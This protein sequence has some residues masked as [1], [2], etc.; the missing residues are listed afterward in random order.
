MKV[1]KFL[2]YMEEIGVKKAVILK[3][4]NINYFLNNYFPFAIALVFEDHPYLY[5][6]KLDKDYASSL[7]IEVREF[8]NWKEIFNNCDAVEEELPIKFLKYLND[9]KIISDKI[10]E[11]RAIKDKDEIKKIEKAVNI[12]D[13]VMDYIY[14]NICYYNN[15]MILCAEIE[16]LM[17]K[18]GS[19]K[20]A[21][22]SIVISGKKT[23]YPHALPEDKKI[24]DILLID[25]GAVYEGYCSD[26][27]RTF[28]LNNN[29]EMKKIYNLVKSAK[30]IVEEH[31]KEG[32][33]TGYL[34][35]LVRKHFGEYN[36]YFIH[37]LGHGVG[38]EVHENPNFRENI[39]LK[40]NMV[41]TIEPGIYI[42]D[43]FGVRLEDMYLIKKNKAKKLSNAK[44]WEDEI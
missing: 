2:N 14:N 16:Y 44:M 1:K 42:K 30:E 43:K 36:N 7:D 24:E 25:I 3:K 33:K 26:I 8:K 12:V 35:E 29:E 40:E 31:L 9:Y 4:E 34:D 6:G 23:S 20:P 10:R 27:T 15:E 19:I 37:S 32:V 28:I 41:I 18:Y 22:E 11:M 21:F 5:V 38:L 13:R 17:K 39:T